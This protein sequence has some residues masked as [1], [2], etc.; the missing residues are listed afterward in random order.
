MDS[1]KGVRARNSWITSGTQFGVGM[2]GL[3]VLSFC[4]FVCYLCPALPNEEY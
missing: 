4:S 2:M 1:V 3:G